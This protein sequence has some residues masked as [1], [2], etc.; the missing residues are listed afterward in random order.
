[1]E[2]GRLNIDFPYLLAPMAGYTDM[3]FRSIC[4]D[5]GCGASFT[6]VV[7][8]QGLVRG[9]KP[10]WHLLETAENEHPVAAHIYG[11]DPDVMARV[12]A[13]VEE[14]GR[15]DF[16]DINCGCP[17]RKIVAKGAGAALIKNPKRIGEIVKAVTDAVDMPVTVKTRIG[18]YD[19]EVM[20][21]EIAREVEANG[22]AMLAIHGR[23]AANHHNGAVDWELIAQIKSELSIPVVGNGGL[24]TAE[25]AVAG[26]DASGVDGVMI[27]RGAVGRP[28]IFEDIAAL[29]RGEEPQ[30]RHHAELRQVIKE[31][32]RRL[33]EQKKLEAL[34]RRKSDFNPDSSAAL[35]FRSHMIQYLRGFSDWQDVRR[36]LN[37]I[38]STDEIL[39]IVDR[40]LAR[41]SGDIVP[42]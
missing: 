26:M 9:S 3:A 25:D 1:M 36:C 38:R 33:V 20:I 18:F 10:S 41:Q 16:V 24:K 4:H 22:A 28:W 17:V 6:E 34:Y 40:V 23:F 32:L 30:V 13:M 29:R 12:A 35:K 21:H 19:G 2:I 5:Y 7:V 42:R 39:E 15:F 11:S 31:H 37:A 14:C 8:A 27:A